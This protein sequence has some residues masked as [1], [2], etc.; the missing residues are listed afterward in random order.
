MVRNL[1]TEPERVE[2]GEGR[3]LP[4]I[5]IKVN[6]IRSGAPTPQH[7]S[8][9]EIFSSENDEWVFMRKIPGEV[10]YYGNLTHSESQNLS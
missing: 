10:S 6:L 3:E 5:S 9:S 8:S 7:L 4:R 2:Y 1:S